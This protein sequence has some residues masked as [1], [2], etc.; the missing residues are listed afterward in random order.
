MRIGNYVFDPVLAQ[1]MGIKIGYAVA[2]LLV[3][4]ALAR[5]AKWAFAKMVDMVP[6]LQRGTGSG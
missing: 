1:E 4:W 6:F 3:V 2:V 5:A